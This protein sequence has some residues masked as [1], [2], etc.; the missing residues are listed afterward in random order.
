MDRAEAMTFHS[1]QVTYKK[2][3]GLPPERFYPI[4]GARVFN[5]MLVIEY[6]NGDITGINIAD[7][8]KYVLYETA[9]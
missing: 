5:G 4:Q 6:S 9:D 7:I 2:A 3:T 8:F 1:L